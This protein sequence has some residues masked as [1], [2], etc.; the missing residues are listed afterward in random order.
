MTR[1]MRLGNFANMLPIVMLLI[2]SE[3]SVSTSS[4][5]LTPQPNGIL[6][7]SDDQGY[8]DQGGFGSTEVKTPH[9]SRLA[10][11]GVRLTSV[12]VAWKQAIEQA[13]PRGLI[14]DY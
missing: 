13:K 8:H 12:Y 10:A 14:R 5:A 7:V 6:I 9:L 3:W 4:A 2:A 11:G 1:P